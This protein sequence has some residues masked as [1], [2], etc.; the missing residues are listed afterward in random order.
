MQ[1]FLKKPIG[2]DSYFLSIL[3]LGFIGAGLTFALSSHIV[4]SMGKIVIT[5]TPQAI[6]VVAII[7][8]VI[9]VAYS[10][11]LRDI[12]TNSNTQWFLVIPALLYILSLINGGGS[13]YSVSSSGNGVLVFLPIFA[14]A[15]F[16]FII[17]LL[18]KPGG[19]AKAK[20]TK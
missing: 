11:R 20:K 19:L 3:V 2:R 15:N 17:F 9:L 16:I 13:P 14:I 4:D 7:D 10:K 12:N 8:I 18:F 1:N 5:M 6:V